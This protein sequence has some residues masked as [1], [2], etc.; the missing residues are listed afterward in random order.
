MRRG[1]Q[2]IRLFFLTP[3]FPSARLS[4]CGRWNSARVR[5]AGD[6]RWCSPTS[7]TGDAAR[8]ASTR[9]H[10]RPLCPVLEQRRVLPSRRLCVGPLCA[11]C[12]DTVMTFARTRPCLHRALA[13]SP[14]RD[15]CQWRTTGRPSRT[16]SL[17][18]PFHADFTFGT[19]IHVVAW[20]DPWTL[21]AGKTQRAPA[22]QRSERRSEVGRSPAASLCARAKRHES[23]E[24]RYRVERRS[25]TGC[26]LAPFRTRDPRVR[27]GHQRVRRSSAGS[28][29]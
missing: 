15:E 22:V 9:L 5:L 25:C 29:D 1:E 8:A 24:H 6:S 27:H 18:P 21:A 28:A 4:R 13:A 7:S 14:K 3:S 16:W 19:V 23:N 17:G 2:A 12:P 10:R 11:F 26:C 20:P